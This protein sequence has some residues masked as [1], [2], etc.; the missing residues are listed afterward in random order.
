M[1]FFTKLLSAEGFPARW[2]CGQWTDFHGWLYVSSD[3]AIWAAYTCIPFILLLFIRRRQDNPFSPIFLLF[4]A[5]IFAC[6][7]THL[8]D[9]VMFW[10]PAY[11]L[12]GLVELITA[13]VSWGAV[14][15]LVK[16]MPMALAYKSPRELE[17]VIETRTRDLA[18]AKER[19]EFAEERYRLVS[20]ATQD[21]IWDCNVLNGNIYW[22]D[23]LYQ[24]LGLDPTEYTPR[25]ETF[26][27]LVH[28]DDRPAIEAFWQT[29]LT[30]PNGP[31]EL[32]YR[33]RHQDG[34][35]R[36]CI[37]KG[38]AKCDATGKA[39]R[40]AGG[41]SDITVQAQTEAALRE[42][43]SRFR[44]LS[45]ANL[46]GIEF[47]DLSGRIVEA[48][49]TFRTMLGLD[50]TL[51][52]QGQLSWNDLVAP[53]SLQ[54][55][56]QRMQQ[57]LA[58]EEVP[59]FETRLR[60]ANGTEL[61]VMMG[62]TLLE[63]TQK[64][65]AAFVL[66]IS[67]RQHAQTQ[68]QKSL[69]R[70]KL[71]RRIVETIN[72]SQDLDFIMMYVA[73]QIGQFF[74]TDRAAI[75]VYD[76]LEAETYQGRL[77]GQY[78]L[79]PAAR[80]LEVQQI[81]SPVRYMTP[82]AEETSHPMIFYKAND[83]NEVPEFAQAFAQTYQIEAVIALEI[84]YRGTLCGRL[85]LYQ[86]QPRQWTMEEVFLL[87]HLITHLGAAIYQFK[88]FQQ[89]QEAKELAQQA[90]QKKS[91]FLA[92]MSHELRTP[93]NAIIGF[94]EMLSSGMTGVL[95]EK[96]YRY[97][98]NISTSGRHLLALINDVLDLSKVEAGKLSLMLEPVHLPTL[99]QQLMASL[100]TL[101]DRQGIR[102]RMTLD[103]SVPLLEADPVRLRQILYN[104]ISNAIKFN[105]P[106]GQVSI[107]VSLSADQQWVSC[108]IE[109]TGIGI[110]ANKI[111]ELFTEFYQVD[112]SFSRKHEGTGLGLALTKR[113]VLLHGGAISVE[114]EENRGSTFS[115]TL[116]VSHRDHLPTPD[117]LA[118]TAPLDGSPEQ[119]M[120]GNN[121]DTL[122][123]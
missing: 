15:A 122:A 58:G 96:Q 114:S 103:S 57:V 63:G 95:S 82:V 6:G 13:L 11:R 28:P 16:V 80:P 84:M 67:Q 25:L 33:L 70:E 50:P 21:G 113:L 27:T 64:M 5:F 22:N 93:L 88:L 62:L 61:A 44:R 56:Q 39:I 76:L 89:E 54:A 77:V 86:E 37:T 73:R 107:Q 41:L 72:Q 111:G 69:K 7:T 106:N 24:I 118:E 20:E 23:Q 36:S 59:P 38:D 102:L 87:E 42:S 8:L 45:D 115:F 2:V 74:E 117:D 3:L 29:Y 100:Q 97:I 101:A 31:F 66:D 81:P 91:Q 4:A 78:A 90:N 52:E 105:R 30:K 34:S 60:S 121:S 120:G 99:I 108:Q 40:V 116:P 104:L 9:A 17:A 83:L 75:L 92:N 85:A 109:D 71:I 49:E 119:A 26:F 46:I 1:T 51:I 65:G 12:T 110:P 48:N 53:E 18:M 98:H 55:H 47:W 10:W 43:E 32:H 14:I 35:Y 19:A 68:L 112:P 79:N 123:S 94:S